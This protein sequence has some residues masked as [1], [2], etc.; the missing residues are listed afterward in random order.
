MQAFW[1]V[2]A[3]QS[4]PAPGAAG[5]HGRGVL[6]P[7]PG[8]GAGL[9]F[10]KKK[11]KEGRKSGSLGRLESGQGWKWI[12]EARLSSPATIPPRQS[13]LLQWVPPAA[14]DS[15]NAHCMRNAAAHQHLKYLSC[16]SLRPR[17]RAQVPAR[18]SLRWEIPS[19]GTRPCPQ[20]PLCS[21]CQKITSQG[22]Q[23]FG[24]QNTKPPSIKGL[25]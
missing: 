21:N 5:G 18:H 22:W 10:K 17:P 2:W 15:S 4:A 12:T 13:L 1:A 16:V 20:Q 14:P 24:Q 9:G 7:T 11:D 6:P 19:T 23:V 3:V 25:N 8:F